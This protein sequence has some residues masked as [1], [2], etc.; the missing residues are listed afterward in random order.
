MSSQLDLP[1]TIPQEEA[2]D[3]PLEGTPVTLVGP[4]NLPPIVF[5]A[6][7]FSKLYNAEHHLSSA[8]PIRTVRLALR[9]GV[10]AFD[11]SAY[12][13]P[14]EIILGNAL[15]TLK[16]E[17]PRSSYQLM[18]KCGRYGLSNFDYSP[19]TIRES[20]KNSLERLKTDY[21]DTVYLHDIEFVATPCLP[22]TS[23]DHSTALKE[24]AALYGLAPGEEG[25]I[26]GEGDQKILDA[27]HELQ[28][29]KA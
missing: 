25:K 28:K 10:R 14:S 12:Y 9:Y 23:G 2:E 17:F 18:T 29:L 22:K 26:R 19:A 8:L 1:T 21:L 27:F 5:G 24:D 4:L 16:D 20:V 7:S 6:A 11:T 13:G 3:L 15:H